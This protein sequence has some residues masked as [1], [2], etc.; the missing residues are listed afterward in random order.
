MNPPWLPMAHSKL[1]PKDPVLPP[2]KPQGSSRTIWALYHNYCRQIC[3]RRVN[4]ESTAPVSFSSSSFFG[5]SMKWWIEGVIS[6]EDELFSHVWTY[7]QRGQA[8]TVLRSRRLID[9]LP[10]HSQTQ[11]RLQWDVYTILISL[12]VFT[13]Q[14]KYL[15]LIPSDKVLLCNSSV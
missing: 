5:H 10:P 2:R 9:P 14:L 13:P 6:E 8:Q 3:T 7:L 4:S 1:P 12:E 15:T 11:T